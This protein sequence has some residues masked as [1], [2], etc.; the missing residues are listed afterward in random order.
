MNLSNNYAVHVA[1]C[2]WRETDENVYQAL[3]RATQP[4]TR[5]WDRLRKAK[6]IAI[7]F[8][9]DKDKAHLTL[10]EGHRQQ[11]VDD[12][13]VR[14]TLRLLRENTHAEINTVD[15][16]FYRHYVGYTEDTTQIRPVLNEFGVQHIE[17]DKDVVW[18]DMLARGDGKRTGRNGLMFDKYPMPRAC[19][20]ADEIISVQKLKSHAFMG[21]TLTTK[22]LFGLMPFEPEGRPRQYY[23]HLVRMPYMLADLARL[24]DPALCILDGMVCQAGEE[25]GKG[26]GLLRFGNCVAAGDNWIATDA[27]GAHLMG[28]PLDSDWL[29]EPFH[30]DRNHLRIAA[31]EGNY[32]SVNL[33]AINWQSEVSAPVAQ[34]F[35]KIT[36][37]RE[38]VYSWR[39]T[40]A[41]QGLYYRD[42]K[43]KFAPYKGQYVLI[44]M[45]EV[46]WSDPSGIVRDSR[47]ILSGANPDQAMWFKYI[48]PDETEGEHFEV[49]ERTLSQIGQMA[50]LA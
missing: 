39:K 46:K 35:A 38:T 11:L 7:K 24:Y 33:N 49:Y 4:L 36:D 19:Y 41:E 50:E 13:V 5:A 48:D 31:D 26:E 17:G 22:N 32:G 43:A 44:Q 42:N 10:H 14:A 20:E 30:R 3:K 45:G 16:A 27:V 8:N 23:H 25:W 40:T 2:D 1:H 47:R 37:S 29:A 12:S 21:V 6:R 15:C 28:H 34:F 9:Q 18:A